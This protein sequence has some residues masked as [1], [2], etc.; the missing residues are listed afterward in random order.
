MVNVKSYILNVYLTSIKHIV[1]FAYVK[2]YMSF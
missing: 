1:L 2:N